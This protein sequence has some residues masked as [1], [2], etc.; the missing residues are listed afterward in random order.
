M[1]S[2]S[3]HRPGTSALHRA[4]PLTKL[5]ALLLLAALLFV[6]PW[7][8]AWAGTLLLLAAAFGLRIGG[9][10][11]RRYLVLATPFLIAVFIFH[12][13]IVDRPDRMPLAAFL[14]Y[15]REGL[16]YAAVLSGRIS[17][18]LTGSL[19]FVATTHPAALLRSLDVAGMPPGLSFLLASPLLLIDEFTK[20]AG[21]IRDAQ[22]ARGM[23]VDTFSD[24]LRA[25][26]LLAV[27][28]VT[29]ALADAQERSGVLNGRAF[30]AFPRRAVLSPPPD[31][32]LERRLRHVLVAVSVLLVGC[33][34]WLG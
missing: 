6:L 9:V 14:S 25:L 23:R 31:T 17:L 26:R 5:A 28:L 10:V 11:L 18:M 29:L 8:G 4:N 20:R 21:A 16:T 13:L 33:A 12:G 7:P 24:R 30:R 2:W 19:L 34:L 32:A 1:R 27:P 15:S 22:Q 3:I